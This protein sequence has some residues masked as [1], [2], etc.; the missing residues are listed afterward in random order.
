[1]KWIAGKAV[2]CKLPFSKD[3]YLTGTEPRGWYTGFELHWLC[4]TSDGKLFWT[5]C[6]WMRDKKNQKKERPIDFAMFKPVDKPATFT[7]EER[8][9]LHRLQMSEECSRLFLE[10]EGANITI[11][12]PN[13]IQ[14][15]EEAVK[16]FNAKHPEFGG[17]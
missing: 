13:D 9:Y 14:L 3:R 12:G 4:H 15:H 8:K 1:M 2:I 16:R 10:E 5:Q 6:K 11:G 17:T 7:E